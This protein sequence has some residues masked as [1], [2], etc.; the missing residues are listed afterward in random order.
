MKAPVDRPASFNAPW[1]FTHVMKIIVKLQRKASMRGAMSF[2]A[3]QSSASLLTDSGTF[4]SMTS[5]VSAMAK[6]PSEKASRRALGLASAMGRDSTL[7]RYHGCL[8]YTSDAAD[9]RSSVDL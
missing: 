1:W 5:S 3:S 2:S 9:E 4:S 8:L 6:T 7:A